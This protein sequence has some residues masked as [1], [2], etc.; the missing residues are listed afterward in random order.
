MKESHR[1][2]HI[3]AIGVILFFVFIH[4]YLY[5]P[6]DLI[7]FDA[8]N[9]PLKQLWSQKLDSN[10]R[11]IT[12]IEGKSLVFVRTNGKVF[13]LRKTQ[14]NVV[15]Q[16]ASSSL[17]ISAPVFFNGSTIFVNDNQSL[18]ALRPDDGQVLWSQPLNS[19]STWIPDASE[20]IVLINELGKDVKA[21]DVQ[22][23]LLLWSVG[24]TRGPKP[25][26]I[27]GDVVYIVDYGITAVDAITGRILWKE[28]TD[29]EGPAA[30]SDGVIYYSHGSKLV[31][32]DVTARKER[33]SHDLYTNPGSIR[34]T[35]NYIMTTTQ[36]YFRAYDKLD[37]HLTWEIPIELPTNPSALENNVY[38]R[39]SYSVKIRV[40]DIDSGKEA[41][42]LR[43]A[44]P[45]FTIEKRDL[46][47]SGNM[48]LFARGNE[49]FA[50]GK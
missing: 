30:Y 24:T 18:W 34:V 39:D 15:W 5:A 10:I 11:D 14:G 46:V 37:G 50:F 17:S 41:G 25:S 49:I 44:L 16:F 26:F 3:L 27:K 7:Q 21:Y 33:W 1:K 2:I 13:A 22:T 6:L 48:L 28:E 32:F 42:S 47:S 8:S 38:V 29:R 20:S 12:V 4:Y 35:N 31:A 45:W 19:Y 40:F 9:F 43:I 23:G 36:L